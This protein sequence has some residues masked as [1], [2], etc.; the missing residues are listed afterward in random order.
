MVLGLQHL[1]ELTEL[2][3]NMNE[4]LRSL[5][6]RL[7]SF[8]ATAGSL[9]EHLVGLSASMESIV[10]SFESV[11][12]SLEKLAATLSY[13]D[14]PLKLATTPLRPVQSVL[15]VVV[16]EVTFVRDLYQHPGVAETVFIDHIKL[17][18]Y[19]SHESVNPT[20]I[21]PLGPTIDFTEPHHRAP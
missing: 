3:D 12:R 21:V 4:T 18:Y 14:I 15:D 8:D 2:L 6:G 10:G 19:G 20:G 7:E 5:D 11:A 17:H 1:G 9:D 16:N 13:L